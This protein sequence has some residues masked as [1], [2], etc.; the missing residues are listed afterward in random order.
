MNNKLLRKVKRARTA[1]KI[2]AQGNVTVFEVTT[3]GRKDDGS[4]RKNYIIDRTYEVYQ[5]S[6]ASYPNTLSDNQWAEHFVMQTELEKKIL[7]S[8]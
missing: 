8:K 4:L 3:C 5:G 1:R 7:A 6:L 2:L